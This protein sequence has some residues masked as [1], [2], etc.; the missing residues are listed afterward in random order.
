MLFWNNY[1]KLNVTT[2]KIYFLF[3]HLLTE[4]SC[5]LLA[6]RLEAGVICRHEVYYFNHTVDILSTTWI[7]CP[8]LEYYAHYL[9][10]M[11]TTWI[12]CPLLGYY[13]HYLNIMSTT[14]ILCPLLEYYVHYFDWTFP[15]RIEYPQ[16]GLDIPCQDWI[17]SA[18][19]GHKDTICL[20]IIPGLQ[21]FIT[22]DI[23]RSCYHAD[24]LANVCRISA[25]LVLKG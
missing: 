25:G 12:L 18:W 24:N 4:P 23:N 20:K 5:A 9:D 19:I 22:D 13:V 3:K 10:I 7:L 2:F 11:S 1:Q 16:L 6:N 17:S 8:L 15:A 21:H 14:W